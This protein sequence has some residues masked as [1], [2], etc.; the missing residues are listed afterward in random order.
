MRKVAQ[1]GGWKARKGCDTHNTTAL[2]SA[3]I[4]SLHKYKHPREADYHFIVQCNGK[5]Y[6]MT[7]DPPTV[8]SGGG[9]DI[10]NSITFSTT[11]P[12]FSDVINDIWVYCDGSGAPVM[13]GGDTPY[14]IGFL[15]YDSSATAY[16]DHYSV[17]IDGRT[18]TE[19]I[20]VA[21]SSDTWYICSPCIAKEIV[22]NLGG[23][24][25]TTSSRTATLKSWQSAA[26]SDRSATDTTKSGTT[27][28]AQDGS[29]T[30]TASASDTMRVMEGRM[31]Y[32][33]EVSF[34]GALSNSID[35]ISCKIKYDVAQITNKWDGVYQLPTNV[36]FRLSSSDQRND[37]TAKVTNESTSLYVQMD[38]MAISGQFL[39]RTAEP[40]TGFGFGI[41]DGYNNT[42]NAQIDATNGVRHW[43]GDSMEN[44]APIVDGTLEGTAGFARTGVLL[45]NA[46]GTTVQKRTESYDPTAAYR[47]LVDCDAELDNTGDDIRCYYITYIPFPESLPAYDGVVQ[48]KGRALY[49]G[50]PQYPNRLR[51]SCYGRPDCLTGSDSGYTDELGDAKVI[52]CAKRFYNELMVW[53]EDSVWL[54][55]GYQPSNLGPLLLAD[56]VGTC[57]PKTVQVIEIGH[58]SMH[59]N[60]PLTVAIW[61]D[62]DGVYLSDGR[63]PRKIS[64]PVDHYF[65]PEYSTAVA[66]DYLDNAQSYNDPNNNEYHLLLSN[67]GSGHGTELVYNYVLDEWYPPW[68]R[69]V[70]G[71]NDF[72]VSGMWLVGTDGRKYTLGGRSNGKVMLLETDTTD[73]DDSDADVKITH[74]V[75]SRAISFTPKESSTFEFTFSEAW[76]EMKARTSPTT[77]TITVNFYKDLATSATAITTPE[78]VSLANSG[79]NLA[80]DGIRTAQNNCKCFQ[81]EFKGDTADLE[82]EIYSFMYAIEGE[83]V[84]SV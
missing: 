60:E 47:Y 28:M 20:C 49:W 80:V 21:D 54:M 1:T 29:L 31:G 48:F 66:A 7:N 75:R 58:P 41:V 25:N 68:D 83:G 76:A 59:S 34:S 15:A 9:T 84:P 53:K 4:L 36:N 38:A 26:W 16:N 77:K 33:Y 69:T 43:D 56:T 27:T 35:V 52:K 18:D 82:L 32:S 6:D 44:N 8:G 13:W 50:D 14:C 61:M 39:I 40:A 24:V 62:T 3:S 5:L 70:G 2:A 72:L 73:R 65:N 79:F 51:V 10:S 67:E 81:L 22:F 17:V 12:G 11:I 45:W 74:Y 55:E 23:T 57:A 78:A 19:A 30:W 42:A 37:V 64:G 71:A 63:K 46:A